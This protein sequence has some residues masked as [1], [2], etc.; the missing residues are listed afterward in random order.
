M[1]NSSLFLNVQ[2]QVGAAL[3]TANLPTVFVQEGGYELNGVGAAVANTLLGFCD[4]DT[5]AA[6]AAAAR[7]DAVP[8]CET[9]S[10]QEQP[11]NQLES[12]EVS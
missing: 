12:P 8:S 7:N 1:V 9:P 3:R 6:I 11:T 2:N 10:P 4:P 5:A